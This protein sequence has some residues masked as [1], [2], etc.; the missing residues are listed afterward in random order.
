[1]ETALTEFKWEDEVDYHLSMLLGGYNSNYEY[2]ENGRWKKNI[3]SEL[4]EVYMDILTAINNR[5]GTNQG[6]FTYPFISTD[7]I[8]EGCISCSYE[9][10]YVAACVHWHNSPDYEEERR[11]VKEICDPDEQ[12]DKEDEFIANLEMFIQ[13]SEY[14]SYQGYPMNAND[15]FYAIRGFCFVNSDH[16]TDGVYL[17]VNDCQNSLARE[18]ADCFNENENNITGFE[19]DLIDV[20]HSANFIRVPKEA[21]MIG[22]K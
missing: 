5:C 13:E 3:E 9:H 4:I 2:F 19:Y 18:T 14:T 16:T 11:E 10:T 20:A 8:E 15:Y 7:D 22:E 1:M 12:S 17:I 6:D 21:R